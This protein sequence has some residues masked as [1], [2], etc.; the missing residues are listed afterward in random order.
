MSRDP[1]EH[2]RGSNPLP[3][4]QP[5]YPPMST[6]D[7][8]IDGAP[9]RRSW[10]AWALAGGLALAVLVGGGA[11]MLWARGGTQ[12]IAATTAGPTTTGA[13]VTTAAPGFP[14][15]DAVVYFFVEDGAQP[16]L[17]PVAR[18][19]AVLSHMVEDP[20]YETL[21]FLVIGTAPG[22]EEA[23]P[24]LVSYIP[25]GTRL[26]GVEVAAG[27]ATV[28][29]SAEFLGG[30]SGNSD[31]IL[32]PA[33]IHRRLAQV[34][35]TLT[36]FPEIYEVRFLIEGGEPGVP[37]EEWMSGGGAATRADFEDLLPPVMIES[38]AYWASSGENPLVVTGTANVFEAVVSLELLAQDGTVLWEGTT[39]ASCGTG[40]RGDFA[41]EI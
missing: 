16:S 23:S 24:A 33:A 7:R 5:I 17:I 35:F 6:A 14:E 4:D 29:L 38:P 28:D 18:P 31:V 34:V 15:D 27:V 32:E 2:L 26:L 3:D 25:E 41:V 37:G 8:I 36:A 19:Y 40:C 20:V 9:R 21:N 1:F 11:W 13:A 22:E 39:M 10:P 12:E 30:G